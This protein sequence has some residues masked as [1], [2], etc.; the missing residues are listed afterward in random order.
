MAT[1]DTL[2]KA[3]LPVELFESLQ[4][5]FG[6]FQLRAERLS[7][8]YGAMQED[9]KRV[10]IELA[11]KNEELKKSLLVQE[12]MRTYL[13]SI[14]ESMD[15]GVIGIT[16]S[17][18]ITHFNRAAAEITGYAPDE[19][20]FKSYRDLFKKQSENEPAL[21]QIL[22]TGKPLK[23][24]EKVL[25]HKDGHPVPVSFQTALLEDR[26]GTRLGAVEIFADVSRIK[27]LEGEMQQART[28]AALGEMS[29]TVAHEIRNP[30]G[31]MGM[32]AELLERDL[33]PGDTR[34]QTLKKIIEGLSRLNKIVSNLLVYTRPAKPE[35]RKVQLENILSEVVDFIEIEIERLGYAITVR[36]EWDRCGLSFVLAD[37]EKIE[38]VIINLCLNA[39]QAMPDGG[40]LTVRVEHPTATGADY[41]GF[42]I[43]D[44]G[45]GIEPENLTKV[46]DPFFT[47]RELGTGLGLA[48]VKKFIESHSGYIDV[49]STPGNGSRFRVFLPK[50]KE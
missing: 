49:D 35:I 29:A 15:N 31:A 41:V 39:M 42:S 30:L 17:G 46:F 14:L 37:P 6:D 3:T 26:G 21:L 25:W 11:A 34:S 9:F 27:A 50:L 4:K 40:E 44:T 20:Y 48:I 38:Q 5:A 8:A 16:T 33:H 13:N 28:M 12:E 47:T 24:D 32:W 10:N 2:E 43:S 7:R 45:I 23:R 19:V 18:I 22:K 36:R 1:A